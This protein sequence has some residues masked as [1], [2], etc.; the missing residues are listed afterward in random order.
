MEAGRSA[1]LCCI[2]AVLACWDSLSDGEEQQ[3]DVLAESCEQEREL[4]LL[5]AAFLLLLERNKHSQGSHAA[6]HRCFPMGTKRR[7]SAS[8]PAGSPSC[9]ANILRSP[10]HTPPCCKWPSALFSTRPSVARRQLRQEWVSV[11]LKLSI[12]RATCSK[13]PAAPKSHRS[14][15]NWKKKCNGVIVE[16]L[17]QAWGLG[18]VTGCQEQVTSSNGKSQGNGREGAQTR[19]DYLIIIRW[20]QVNGQNVPRWSPWSLCG[21]GEQLVSLSSPIK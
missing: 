8:L 20:Q 15:A 13:A 2:T 10:K 18:V 16:R 3:A 19:R 12:S 17:C 14:T 11:L 1:L 7:G 6:W 4:L 5:P 9:R 21:R